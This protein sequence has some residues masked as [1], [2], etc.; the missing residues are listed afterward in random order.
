MWVI[1][2]HNFTASIQKQLFMSFVCTEMAVLLVMVKISH[3]H[4][5]YGKYHVIICYIARYVITINFYS[6]LE[7]QAK[8]PQVS[9]KS[10]F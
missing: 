4:H 1:D 9:L 7:V 3:H 10:T 8:S 5:F 2:I 6:T